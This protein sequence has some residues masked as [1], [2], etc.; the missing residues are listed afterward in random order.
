M[1]IVDGIELG[2]FFSNVF[3]PASKDRRESGLLSAEGRSKGEAEATKF[4]VSAFVVVCSFRFA[5]KYSSPDPIPRE[6]IGQ[7]QKQF[8]CLR[9]KVRRSIWQPPF[10]SKTPLTT[11]TS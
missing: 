10:Y 7:T 1:V 11:P 4:I 3:S 8:R 2:S 9:E 6:I 5:A